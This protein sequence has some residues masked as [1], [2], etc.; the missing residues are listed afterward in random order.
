MGGITIL[1]PGFHNV[2]DLSYWQSWLA[3]VLED[4]EIDKSGFCY[5]TVFQH[6]PIC[7]CPN[8]TR[9]FWLSIFSLHH[10]CKPPLSWSQVICWSCSHVTLSSNPP[11]PICHFALKFTHVSISASFFIHPLNEI[12][13]AWLLYFSCD[14]FAPHFSMFYDQI[15]ELHFLAQFLMDSLETWTAHSSICNLDAWYIINANMV[16]FKIHVFGF[17]GWFL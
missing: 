16:S 2:C 5:Q 13:L 4:N 3:A 14:F 11:F 10:P 6:W 8:W 17:L 15:F 7:R 12:L 9:Q 1:S